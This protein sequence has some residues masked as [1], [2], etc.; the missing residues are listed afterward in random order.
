MTDKSIDSTFIYDQ[1]PYPSHS[2]T[3]SHP[4]RLATLATLLGM[5]PPPVEHC[6][7]LELG[8]AGGGNL[9]PMAQDLP[10]SQFV[11]VDLSGREIADGQATVGI[12]GLKN[13][14]LKPMNILDV[15]AGFG[16]FDYI[17]THGIYSWVPPAVQDKILA[18][19]KQN[20]APNGVA[21][22][23]YNTYP[24]WRLLGTVRDMMLYHTRDIADP[25]QK[26]AEARTL[27]EFL[28]ES[29]PAN[30]SPHS[31]FLHA[32]V[33]FFKEQTLPKGA[34]D[35]AYLLHD[36]LAGVNEPLYFYQ[37]AERAA[38]H[39]LKY[40]AEAN[41]RTMLANNFP[42]ETVRA[43]RQVAK[44]TIALEQYM[45]FLRNRTF[46]QTL[47]CHQDVR[48]SAALDPERMA[49]F[50]VGSLALPA[51]AE[52]DA[53][54]TSVEQFRSPDHATLSTDHPVTKVAMRYLCRIWPQVVPFETLLAVA[55]ARL[56]EAPA[57]IAADAQML[58]ANLL[59]AYGYSDNLVELH[60][61]APHFVVEVSERPIASPVVRFYAERRGPVTNVRHE[62]VMLNES[63]Y[64]LL[65]YLDG[66]RDRAALLEIV[67]ELAA[68]GLVVA[69][70]D[71]EPAE[72]AE[73]DRPG[74]EPSREETPAELLDSLLRQLAN[75]ALLVG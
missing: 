36:E 32:Y 70:Q 22:V 20:L 60:I 29:I 27:I 46:R 18:I 41:F 39:G 56:S 38:A 73:Q 23:S 17:I 64:H 57:D 69:E 34:V 19:C 3:A 50:Y 53:D 67:E 49:K 43:L 21:Y 31:S 75:A 6:R 72:A 65:P 26:V 74:S 24:G 44:S 2:F 37:F 61:Y 40:M 11:G 66:S 15:D 55:R 47:L 58:G 25:H 10:D 62:R 5:D 54:S 16:Q 48:L 71:D 35:D 51:S 14:S 13:V 4:D 63:S 8:C 9:I 33:N 68:Q 52:P 7:V 42:D 30:F 1:V 12:L 59:K 28:A 45:D